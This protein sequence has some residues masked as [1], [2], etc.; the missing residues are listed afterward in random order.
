MKPRFS[1][2]SEIDLA[3]IADYIAADSPR[4]AI[5]FVLAL[6]DKANEAALNP[7]IYP[8]ARIHPRPLR[9]I[10]VGAYLIWFSL[11]ERDEVTIERILH[12]ASE[13]P[14]T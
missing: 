13:H 8:V 1:R 3:R 12:S 9:R 2:L 11:G 7:L 5:R 10:V 14:E 6:R 4:E